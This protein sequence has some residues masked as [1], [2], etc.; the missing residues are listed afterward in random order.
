MPIEVI[1]ALVGKSD[2]AFDLQTDNIFGAKINKFFDCIKSIVI[3]RNLRI[4]SRLSF[5]RT[6]SSYISLGT[7]YDVDVVSVRK[8]LDIFLND[9]VIAIQSHLLQKTP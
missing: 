9:S 2:S 5:D 7:S 8:Q 4:N 6:K 1:V 3:G